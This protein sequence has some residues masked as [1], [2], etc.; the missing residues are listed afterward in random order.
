[1]IVE[2][3]DVTGGLRLLQN[4]L[5]RLTEWTPLAANFD[6]DANEHL[7]SLTHELERATSYVYDGL[8]RPIQ[9]TLPD[10]SAHLADFR[11]NR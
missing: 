9:Q 2:A 5:I 7:L 11:T 3:L 10:I 6:Y 4:V 8:N 1:V